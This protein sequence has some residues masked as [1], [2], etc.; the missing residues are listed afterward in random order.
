[1]QTSSNT[2]AQ[3]KQVTQRVLQIG[4]VLSLVVNALPYFSILRKS[5]NQNIKF[6]CVLISW[7]DAHGQ[8]SRQYS[9]IEKKNL[10]IHGVNL[11]K[12][13]NNIIC[14]LVVMLIATVKGKCVRRI[15]VV[16]VITNVYKLRWCDF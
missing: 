3:T 2:P 12:I 9:R 4:G 8:T 15:I 1:M 10:I 14:R 7:L 13:S 5:I 11:C 6:W 16:P